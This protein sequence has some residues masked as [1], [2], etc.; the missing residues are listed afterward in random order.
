MGQELKGNVGG[1]DGWWHRSNTGGTSYLTDGEKI[2]LCSIPVYY[3]PSRRAPGENNQN[4][5]GWAA[6]PHHDYGIV[7]VNPAHYVGTST[8]AC[9]N[10]FWTYDGTTV[11][12][13]Q[14]GAVRPPIVPLNATGTPQYRNYTPRDTFAWI[15]DGLSNTII[16]GEKHISEDGL[17]KC[18]VSN[19]DQTARGTVS[20]MDCSYLW[21]GSG[22]GDRNGT[23][24]RAIRA[25][26][27]SITRQP[28]TYNGS[29]GIFG[30]YHASGACNFL[31]G[32]GAVI[33]LKPNVTETVLLAIARA[34]D[35]TSVE[36]PN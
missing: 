1:L 19:A 27:E 6:G 13:I 7:I 31:L 25:G 32:D 35:G 20:K 12:N 24:A 11:N 3:C 36:I 18:A 30:S 9:I 8:S 4:N 28:K 23:V 5:D 17:N 21:G 22:S 14:G 34:C 29:S 26:T 2:G 15:S 16:I 33:S 10:N